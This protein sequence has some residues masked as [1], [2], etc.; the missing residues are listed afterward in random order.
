[1]IGQVANLRLGVLQLADVAGGQQQAGRLIERDRLNR[2]FNRKQF[3][4]LVAP[5]HFVMV[6]A[7]LVLQFCDEARALFVVSPD[8]DF[9]RGAAD[10]FS[11]AVARQTAK[12]VVDLQ[13]ATAVEFSDGDRVGAG[14]KRLGELFFAGL[15]RSLGSLL[16]GDV[17]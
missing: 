4:A 13:V 1:M 2:D 6:D 7:A 10:H 11:A 9:V 3:A 17:A 5:E 15:E 12:A 16:L 14:V 8:T